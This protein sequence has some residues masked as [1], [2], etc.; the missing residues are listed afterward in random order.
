[1]KKKESEM[2]NH[3]RLLHP[4]EMKMKQKIGLH[5]NSLDTL[6]SFALLI[7]Y[8]STATLPECTPSANCCDLHI[9]DSSSS[10]THAYD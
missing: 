10:G 6:D 5:V 3:G 7:L 1:M 9:H 2:R 8:L 4:E